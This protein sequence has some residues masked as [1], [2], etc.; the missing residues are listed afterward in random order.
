MRNRF[1]VPVRNELAATDL[2]VD[3]GPRLPPA[4]LRETVLDAL[5]A[6]AFAGTSGYT[7]E[8]GIRHRI[9][10]SHSPPPAT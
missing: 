4:V 9:A 10:Y 5:T 3:F 8:L 2:L 6:Q 7:T 1:S